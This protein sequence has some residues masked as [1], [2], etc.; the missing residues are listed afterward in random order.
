MTLL[1]TTV[2]VVVTV[3]D[4]G[5]II[6]TVTGFQGGKERHLPHHLNVSYLFFFLLLKILLI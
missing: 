6:V 1:Q 2:K 5:D 4:N 3:C